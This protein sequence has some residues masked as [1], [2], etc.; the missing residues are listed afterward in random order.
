MEVFWKKGYQNTSLDAL[1]GAMGIQRGSFYNTFGSKKEVY[2]RALARYADFMTNGGPYTELAH[3]EPSLSVL[4]DM[5]ERYLGSV[6]GKSGMGGCFFAHAAKEHRGKD[7][8]VRKTMLAGIELMQ[9][10]IERCIEAAK[11][12][13]QLPEEVESR[14]LALLFMSVAWGLHV[15]AEAGVSNEKLLAAGSQLFALSRTEP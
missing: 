14:D 8:S 3:S 11:T 1:L 15:M 9:G 2:L 13:G 6:T 12:D 4:E 7:P 5:L 10:I